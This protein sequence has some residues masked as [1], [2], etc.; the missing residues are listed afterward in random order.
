MM[1]YEIPEIRLIAFESA[2]VIAAS[3][4]GITPGDDQSPPE[5]DL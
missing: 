4:D 5:E 2:D 3:G 1:K